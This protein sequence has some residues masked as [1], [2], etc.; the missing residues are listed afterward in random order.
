MKESDIEK[1]TYQIFK[2][3]AYMQKRSIPHG[4]I[5]SGDILLKENH[6]KVSD[7]GTAASLLLHRARSDE[8]PHPELLGTFPS[9]EVNAFR[10]L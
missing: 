3:L 5:H 7:F 9:P 10:L 6:V 4:D 8:K 2:A 1:V